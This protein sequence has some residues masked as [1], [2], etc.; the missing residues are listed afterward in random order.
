MIL[1]NTR[2]LTCVL[3]YLLSFLLLECESVAR[4]AAQTIINCDFTALQQAAT[5]GGSY[6]LDCD[7]T[8]TFAQPLVISNGVTFTAAPGR[9]VSFDG[10]K[11][12]QLFDV[13]PAG[14]LT[15]S[16]LSL[17]NGYHEGAPG[18]IIQDWP[19][20]IRPGD[21]TGGAIKNAGS[22][23][24][25]NCLFS[26]NSAKGG[27]EIYDGM[28]FANAIGDSLGGTV[29]S[30]GSL[31]LEKC[32]ITNSLVFGK[33]GTYLISAA[34]GGAIYIAAGEARLTETIIQK[35]FVEAEYNKY[36]VVPSLGGGIAITGGNLHLM[37]SIIS[38]CSV[39]PSF[40]RTET[41]S[42]R[43]GGLYAAN[44]RVEIFDSTFSSNTAVGATVRHY[45]TGPQ[46]SG[47][48][49]E[50]GGIYLDTN[51]TAVVFNSSFV[52]NTARGADSGNGMFRYVY[53]SVAGHGGAI[54]N[55]GTLSLT[56]CTFGF[57]L[58]R[59]GDAE[60]LELWYGCDFSGCLRQGDVIRGGAYGG[61][62]YLQPASTTLINFCTIAQNR[63]MR[64]LDPVIPGRDRRG[65]GI[66]N[67][68]GGLQVKNSILA[69]NEVE[70]HSGPVQNQGY[71]L[72]SDLSLPPDSTSL[73][74]TNPHLGSLGLHRGTTPVFPLANASPARDRISQTDVSADQRG[75][76]R[77]FGASADIGAFELDLI[78]Y[79]IAQR[80][81]L[82]FHTTPGSTWRFFKSSNLVDWTELKHA[83]AT[84]EQLRVELDQPGSPG[85]T[86]Y[87]AIRE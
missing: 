31:V 84:S 11:R 85:A 2:F 83:T 3:F 10:A 70:N 27:P 57:N 73:Q 35:S 32:T 24:A 7:A 47:Q 87:R 44:S 45:I 16:N 39:T 68:D 82:T 62:L 52:G 33:S 25:V 86:F 29:F 61:A 23:K 30:S 17:L 34:S 28:T 78:N 36:R 72:S 13:Q 71:N 74:N 69:F 12:T 14:S 80:G 41:G 65:G 64:A 53:S 37:S 22:L 67:L 43:G 4:P 58:A 6:L 66:F 79:F 81:Q 38:N 18:R 9:R 75:V 54:N 51:A 42:S 76:S 5:K 1:G 59:G 8:I 50:G 20:S 26:G 49:G 40:S 77:P 56:N 21:G 19:G 55:A 46:L 63:V 48:P 15:L 60:V